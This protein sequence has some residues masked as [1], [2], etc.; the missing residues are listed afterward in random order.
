MSEFTKLGGYLV[1][2]QPEVAHDNTLSGNGLP[3]SPLGFVGAAF[4][5]S[6]EEACEAVTANSATWNNVTGKQDT[7]TFGYDS[8]NA[9]SSINNSALAGGGLTGDY[10]SGVNTKS[11]VIG[12]KIYTTA[13]E[14]NGDIKLSAY[15]ARSNNPSISGIQQT[16]SLLNMANTQSELK[17]YA[18][19]LSGSNTIKSVG[20]YPITYEMF[21]SAYDSSDTTGPVNVTSFNVYDYSE[22]GMENE[23]W[24]YF[25]NTTLSNISATVYYTNANTI[26]TEITGLV[27]GWTI[28]TL[29]AVETGNNYGVY[30]SLDTTAT[31][32]G[33]YV[34]F[35]IQDALP[36][37]GTVSA[38]QT[39]NVLS[40]IAFENKFGFTTGNEISGYNGSGFACGAAVSAN[41]PLSG[42]GSNSQPLGLDLKTDNSLSGNGTLTSPLG[43]VPGYNETVL[44]SGADTTANIQLSEPISSFD[45]L[46]IYGN[47]YNTP[48][49]ATANIID[50]S[51]FSFATLNYSNKTNES[52]R[53]W[54]LA[55]TFTG[56]SNNIFGE[57]Y[58]RLE[59]HAQTSTAITF[60][61]SNIP[62]NKVIG[63][64]R[65]Q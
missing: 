53:L 12:T 36:S 18:G 31:E 50:T 14:I 43:V 41:A 51:S 42:D 35:R 25:E 1:E 8:S 3:G 13:T 33:D 16:A 9:I 10:V 47:K 37:S 45:Y 19:M 26:P 58:Y 49:T 5:A 59:Y 63:I 44:W 64:N 28:S 2:G 46:K 32:Q 61:Q 21:N 30:T 6:A 17:G 56:N 22:Y 57:N 48:F 54:I 62:I 34:T 60:E 55:A 39:S 11:E 40:K 24:L 65:K 15:T 23:L 29:T 7:L 52:Q 27:D 4:P 20:S 38:K